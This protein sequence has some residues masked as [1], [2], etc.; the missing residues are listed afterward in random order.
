MAKFYGN[1]GYVET[2]EESPG[3]WQEVETVKSYYGDML[4]NRTNWI[5]TSNVNSNIKMNHRI[6]ILADS[7]AFDH[8]A[9]IRWA[10]FNG[11]KWRVSDIS[12]EYPRLI[13]S[14]GEVYNDGD[15]A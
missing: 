4:Q 8:S 12:A 9:Y 10:E 5:D 7:Y 15:Q 11:I 1:V 6:S 14:L 3:V 13:L 2:I